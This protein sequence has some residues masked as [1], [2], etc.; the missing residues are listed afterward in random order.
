M[1][2]DADSP[3]LL[4]GALLCVVVAAGLVGYQSFV[5]DR[6]PAA[7]SRV[8]VAAAALAGILGIFATSLVGV[9][10]VAYRPIGCITLAASLG[11]GFVAQRENG[12]ATRPYRLLQ[13]LLSVLAACALLD[14]AGGSCVLSGQ[15][16]GIGLR[17]F[18]GE[19]L[20]SASYMTS[21]FNTIVL[22]VALGLLL[23]GF[24]RAWRTGSPRTT[25][26]ALLAFALFVGSWLSR[27]DY[28]SF[29][30]FEEEAGRWVPTTCGFF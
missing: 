15:V 9:P 28:H 1:L 23:V 6:N 3:L 18:Q 4:A 11:L 14:A 8:G 22:I 25:S 2:V 13:G 24:V 20:P 5:P 27:A 12:A 19:Y 21:P 17:K 26:V 10:T 30:C 7:W 16:P 29:R